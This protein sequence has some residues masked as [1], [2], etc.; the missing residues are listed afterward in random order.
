MTNENTTLAIDAIA[1]HIAI[2]RGQRVIVDAD[3]AALYGVP[4]K[5][6]NEQVRRNA[7]R[8]P[9]D[10]MFQLAQEEWDALRSQIATLKTGRGQHR[11]YLPFAFTEHGAIMAATV[12]NSPR[13]VEVSIY[14]VRAFVQLREL[15]TGHKELA[16]RLDQLETRMERKLITQDQAI[17][18]ILDAIRQLMAPPPTPKKRPIGFITPQ[19]KA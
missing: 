6:L 8:F 15:L 14:V 13:A 3:L 18:G 11:K 10:F 5:R 1:G 7:E 19:D 16:K 17:A 4:T 9:E 12:L 2:M